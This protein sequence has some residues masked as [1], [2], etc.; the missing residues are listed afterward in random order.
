M[1]EL[2]F[3]P[4]DVGVSQM[5]VVE[6]AVDAVNAC[7][8]E[9]QPHLYANVLLVGGCA[10]FPGFRER[11]YRDL[12]SNAPQE[13]DVNVYLPDEWVDLFFSNPLKLGIQ[14]L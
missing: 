2:L 13:F 10:R 9:T 11:L 6:A 1:P 14:L 7:P 3:H 5:G 8:P 4:S 12:R